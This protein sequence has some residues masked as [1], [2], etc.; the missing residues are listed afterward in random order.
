M[1]K[2]GDNEKISFGEFYAAIISEPWN[3]EILLDSIQCPNDD[4]RSES[5]DEHMREGKVKKAFNMPKTNS[6]SVNAIKNKDISPR[7]NK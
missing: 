4:Q 3:L 5:L 1:Y 6:S 7:A 2:N